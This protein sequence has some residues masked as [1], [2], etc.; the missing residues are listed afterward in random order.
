MDA[1]LFGL[2]DGNNFYASCE[3]VFDPRLRGRPVVVLSNNDGCAIA[4][5]HEAKRLGIKMGQPI[6]EVPTDVRKQC[7]VRSANFGLYG[8]MSG[9]VVQV[10]RDLFPRVE[11]YS[12]DE[13]FVSFEGVR[14]PVALATEARRR[15]LQWT[16]IPCCVGIGAT[17]TLAKAG[18]KMAKGTTHGVVRVERSM[19]DSYPVEDVWGVGRRF[20][21]RLGA[22]GILT[23]GDLARAD[24]ETL[25]ARYGVV[26][27]RTQMELNGQPCSDLEEVEP[28]RKELVVSRS[29][30]RE[31]TEL[32]DLS[33]AAATFAI[34][35]CEK[36][37]ARSLK[38]N[39]VWV[40]VNTNPFKPDAPQYHPSQAFNLVRPT[41]DTRE[42]LFVVQGLLKAMHR[43]GYRYKKAGVGLLDLVDSNVVQGDLFSPQEEPR[44]SKS[45][46]VMDS[47]NRRFGRGTLGMG[48]SGWK[49][50]PMW[51]M[52]QESL[53]PAY[54]TKWSDVMRVR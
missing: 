9:R 25:R 41:S 27:S 8:D 18:N 38:A 53:S 6:H 2:V 42:I 44:V 16:G 45:M 31:V 10:L 22:E 26:L 23:A 7:I 13:S 33:Q 19:L 48:S 37:R 5:S 46:E 15:I 24:P 28:Q 20:T 21:A 1:S 49:A 51:G 54:T 14:D 29:F 47:I 52:R 4:R 11:V 3:R 43:P 39:G 35:A 34:R 32:A 40:W 12:I 36:L 17:K 50:K 30:G